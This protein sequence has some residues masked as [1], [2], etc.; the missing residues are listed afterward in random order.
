MRHVVVCLNGCGVD[1]INRYATDHGAI[2]KPATPNIDALCDAGVRFRRHYTNPTGSGALAHLFTGR[3]GFKTG[4]SANT[5][6]AHPGP[7][8]NTE[9]WLAA[10]LNGTHAVEIV[11]R[12]SL[13]TFDNGGYLSPLVPPDGVCGFDRAIGTVGDIAGKSTY[14]W[15][16]RYLTESGASVLE[17]LDSNEM[18]VG[19]DDGS[20]NRNP[21]NYATK[22]TADDAIARLTAIS[23]SPFLLFICFNA[24]GPPFHKPPT[25][26]E[27]AAESLGPCMSATI[28]TV[29]VAYEEIL[30]ETNVAANKAILASLTPP[31]PIDDD[32]LEDALALAQYLGM[33]EVVD[34]DLGRIASHAGSALDPTT[35]DV[36][37]WVTST[38]GR[39][40]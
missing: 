32:D 16:P 31:W 39:R 35:G 36:Q 4:V 5:M 7:P 14:F 34:F 9:P 40:G 29:I 1:G 21:L 23:A 25:A 19:A 18:M 38:G 8:L 20:D 30:A 15:W 33:M 6:P 12:H 28:E 26:A 3:H 22:V 10:A 2:Y 24:P 11:G 37:L 17:N 13:G 27:R